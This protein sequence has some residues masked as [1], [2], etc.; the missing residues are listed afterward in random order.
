MHKIRN[1]LGL[2]ILAA[3][4]CGVA[5]AAAESELLDKK[6]YIGILRQEPIRMEQFPTQKPFLQLNS[7]KTFSAFLGCNQLSGT[8]KITPPNGLELT[9]NPITPGVTCQQEFIDLEQ[10]F[11]T[12]LPAVKVW[13]L[14]SNNVLSFKNA[15]DDIL[16]VML[17]TLV[18][19]Y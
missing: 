9:L 11:A 7:D 5:H 1:F 3:L 8:L 17:L 6:W 14:N 18:E 4:G 2:I 10:D 12:A 13:E 19:P 15:V 16:A